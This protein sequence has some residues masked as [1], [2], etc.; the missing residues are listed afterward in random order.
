MSGKTLSTGTLSLRFM[1]NAQQNKQVQ[2]DKAEVAD[3]GAWEVPK[4][5][6]D[7]WDEAAPPK[8]VHWLLCFIFG[9]HV[10][11][12]GWQERYRT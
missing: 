3:D 10:L 2:L 8:Y 6:R 4:V 1:R 11:T 5:V 12:Y 7:A 9:R